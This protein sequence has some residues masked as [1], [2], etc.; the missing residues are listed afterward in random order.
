MHNHRQYCSLEYSNFYVE[1]RGVGKLMNG[2][3]ILFV[4]SQI[5]SY[6]VAVLRIDETDKRV[7]IASILPGCLRYRRNEVFASAVDA[8]SLCNIPRMRVN[9]DVCS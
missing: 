7:Q 9:V 5:W 1:Q 3:T 4:A 6:F 8:S 2:N